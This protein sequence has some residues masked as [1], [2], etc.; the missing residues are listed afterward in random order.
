MDRSQRRAKG[1]QDTTEE[2]FFR[3]TEP[4]FLDE[5]RK[6]S[7]RRSEL[8]AFRE[9]LARVNLFDPACGCSNFL[10]IAYRELRLLEI[11]VVR[12]L[13]AYEAVTGSR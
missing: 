4:L 6:D 10:V 8:R 13:R 7:R 3:V 5:L 2:N 11:K 12:A 1:A 9:R